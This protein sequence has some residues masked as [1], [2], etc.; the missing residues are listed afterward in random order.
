MKRL[1]VAPEGRGAGL[2]AALIA[3]AVERATTL[4]YREMRLD[5]LP[6]MQAALALYRAAGFTTI[7]AYYPTPIPDT[8]FLAKRLRG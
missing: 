7:E 1:Y 4:G 5:T 8:V 6:S 3:T 2:G